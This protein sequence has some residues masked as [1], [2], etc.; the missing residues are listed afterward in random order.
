[1]PANPAPILTPAHMRDL[2]K[3]VGLTQGGMAAAL[4]YC[5]QRYGLWERGKASMPPH[6]CDAFL[7]IIETLHSKHA[8][9]AA[10]RDALLAHLPRAS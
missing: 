8:A 2:R 3:D 1:M 5:R 9:R 10:R 6:V 7:D 4:G